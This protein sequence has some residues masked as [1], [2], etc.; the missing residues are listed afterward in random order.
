MIVGREALASFQE[1]AG[2]GLADLGAPEGAASLGEFFRAREDTLGMAL[3]SKLEG[4][5]D[6]LGALT[7]LDPMS[8]LHRIPLRDLE[9]FESADEEFEFYVEDLL[10]DDLSDAYASQLADRQ[11][12][13]EGGDGP[14]L[15]E[16]LRAFDHESALKELSGEPS[17]LFL[18]ESSAA[19]SLSHLGFGGFNRCPLPSEHALIWEHWK[20][21]F[22]AEPVLLG[23]DTI[24]G[25]V[26]RPASDRAALVRFAMEVALYDY[27]ALGSGFLT[28]LG[29]LYR[30][31]SI[32]FWWD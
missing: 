27:D 31:A 15:Q 23:P 4:S 24:Y 8:V 28:L 11:A 19:L 13:I 5:L 26:E 10:P 18:V 3:E 22:G 20:Q 7:G 21:S 9:M 1:R 6:K 25:V 29:S 14:I 12:L 32:G 30:N 16:P 2:F 17:R